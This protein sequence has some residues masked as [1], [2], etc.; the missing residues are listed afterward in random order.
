MTT[1]DTASITSSRCLRGSQMTRPVLPRM[2]ISSMA[3]ACLVAWTAISCTALPRTTDVSPP[4]QKTVKC[5]IKVL[6]EMPEVSQSRQGVATSE[7]WP[8]P[9]V[10]YRAA[11]A[12]TRDTSIR[13]SA[14]KADGGGYWFLAVKSG[15]GAPE[16]H[17]TDAVTKKWKIRCDTDAMV[18][19]P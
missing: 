2:R 10:E 17:V 3:V 13:F 8:Q 11:E 16:F 5:M 9:F 14:K 15:L 1:D 19:F 4:L 7:G 12:L 18:L 6:K